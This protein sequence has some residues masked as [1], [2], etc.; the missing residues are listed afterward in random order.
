MSVR[1]E[2]PWKVICRTSLHGRSR[3]HADC[4]FCGEPAV[5]FLWSFAGHGKKKCPCGAAFYRDGVSRKPCS[6]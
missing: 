5:I 4:P 3:V 6:G 2:R 1:D